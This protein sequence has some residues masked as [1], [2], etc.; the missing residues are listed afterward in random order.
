MIKTIYFSNFVV[1]SVYHCPRIKD[2]FPNYALCVHLPIKFYEERKP[3]VTI[4]EGRGALITVNSN[5]V[6][7]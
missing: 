2:K 3:V 7:L 4:P 1:A 5:L 6:E